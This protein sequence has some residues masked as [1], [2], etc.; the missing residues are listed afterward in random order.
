MHVRDLRREERKQMIRSYRQRNFPFQTAVGPVGDGGILIEEWERGGDARP[1]GAYASLRGLYS[2]P[3]G[4]TQRMPSGDAGPSAVPVV[5][6]DQQMLWL[7]LP[8]KP[9]GGDTYWW[10]AALM[11]LPVPDTDFAYQIDASY[12]V[13]LFDELTAQDEATPKPGSIGVII[14]EDTLDQ[15]G[16]PD[17][18][19]FSNTVLDAGETSTQPEIWTDDQTLS[20]ASPAQADS[21]MRV[22]LTILMI[23][24]GGNTR[25]I[26]YS[27]TDGV[28]KALVGDQTI[29]NLLPTRI[30]FAV[31]G[32]EPAP[33]DAGLAA[34]GWFDYLRVR[35]ASEGELGTVAF[36]QTG[37][38][39]W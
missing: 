24:E 34:S 27:S 23:R 4:W 14:G 21:F 15:A 32:E 38:R 6:A 16:W 35:L 39:N 36:G 29:P 28:G 20:S 22:Y 2:L 10:N 11:T 12:I 19:Y 33:G 17:L 3:A 9:E 7:A 37:G 30:G 13:G 25:F 26:T 8:A 18:F 5:S 1:G 31:R